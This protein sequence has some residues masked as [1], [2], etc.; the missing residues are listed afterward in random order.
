VNGFG[1]AALRSLGAGT[2]LNLFVGDGAQFDGVQ[3]LT[4]GDYE[5]QGW[6]DFTI[7][8][9]VIDPSAP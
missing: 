7:R 9:E 2:S 8:L 1:Y 6:A 5:V 3:V 4:S